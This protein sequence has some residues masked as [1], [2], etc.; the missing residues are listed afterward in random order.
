GLRGSEAVQIV[1]GDLDLSDKPALHIRKDIAKNGLECTVPLTQA[2]AAQL[3]EV[4]GM[5]P[6]KVFGNVAKDAANRRRSFKR[7]VRKAGLDAGLNAR[8]FRMTHNTW[9]RL[10]GLDDMTIGTLRRDK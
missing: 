5:K 6:G 3:L 2:L 9:L 7:H 8:S 4:C 10:A 1:R